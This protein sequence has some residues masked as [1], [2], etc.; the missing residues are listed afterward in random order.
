MY[1]ISIYFFC[2]CFGNTA[3]LFNYNIIYY[4]IM[5][6]LFLNHCVSNYI[7]INYNN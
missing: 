5:I 4:E 6:Q 7:N 2:C 1:S 3:N